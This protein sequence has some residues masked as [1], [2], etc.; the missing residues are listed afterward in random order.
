MDQ[1]VKI[2][3][4]EQGRLRRRPLVADLVSKRDD[5]LLVTGLGGATYDV[6]AAGD[7]DKN[8][9]FWGGMGLTAMTGLGVAIAQPDRRVVVITGDGD[10]MMGIGSLATIASAA[11]SNLAI[12]V[13]DNE[14]FGETGEQI[15]LSAGCTDMALMAKGAGFETTATLSTEE[16]IGS[17]PGLLYKTPG[18]VFVVAKVAPGNDERVLP[19]TDGAYLTR[20]FRDAL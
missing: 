3:V 11:P 20:R 12:L 9:Y 7:S 13:L 14:R 5:A 8:F 6:A 18:P 15:G 1:Q 19:S 2:S 16:E 17:L 10:M 4:D